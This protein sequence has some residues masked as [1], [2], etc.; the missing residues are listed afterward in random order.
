MAGYQG[1]WFHPATSYSVPVALRLAEHVARTPLE[2]LFGPAWQ[3]MVAA[4]RRQQ[5]F[6]RTLNYLLFAGTP[7]PSRWRVMSGFYRNPEDTLRR[8]YALALT[9]R[10]QLR[11]MN[12]G[13][14]WFLSAHVHREEE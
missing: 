10:D 14:W 2:L 9:G 13:F 12:R 3:R 7:G 8:F 6:A 4:H 5:V 11:I 1:G